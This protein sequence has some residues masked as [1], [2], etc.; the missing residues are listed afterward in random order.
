MGTIEDL[1]YYFPRYHH[2]YSDIVSINELDYE[3]IKT[4]KVTLG[5]VQNVRLKNKRVKNMQKVKAF[6]DDGEIDVVW[7]NQPFI[8]DILKEGDEVYFAA[9]LNEKSHKPQITNPEYE[10]AKESEST[11]V[12]RITPIYPLTEG[13]KQKW[14]RTKIKWLIDKLEFVTDLDDKLNTSIREKYNLEDLRYSITNIHFPDSK[15]TLFKAR[16]R[17][18][19][20]EMLAI[21]LKLEKLRKE[22]LKSKAPIIHIDEKNSIS[23]KFIETLPFKLTNDQTQ[24]IEIIKDDIQKGIPMKRLLHGD[25]GSGKTL[26]AIAASLEVVNSGLDAVIMAP[27]TV[28]AKQLHTNFSEFLEPFNLKIDLY[29]SST[30]NST[31]KASKGRG[32]NLKLLEKTPKTDPTKG[33][34]IIGTHSLLFLNEEFFSNMGILVIDEQHRF[35]VGQRNKISEEINKET[36]EEKPHYLMMTATPIPRTM[37]MTFFGDM[38]LTLISEKPKDRKPLKTFLVP[39]RKRKDGYKWIEDQIKVDNNQVFW[40]CPLID[41]S[42]KLQTKSVKQTYSELT[43]VYPDLKIELLHGQLKEEEKNKLLNDFKDK[44]FDILVSTSVIEVGIDIPNANYIVIEGAERFGL[45]QLH[46][47]RGR[48]GRGDKQAY[49][50]LFH[51]DG[52]TSNNESVERLKYF[53][54]ENDGLKIAEYDLERRGPGEVYGTKQSGIPNLRLAKLTDVELIKQ[55]REAAKILLSNN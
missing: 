7:F 55:T 4:I 6:D 16:N 2:D 41:E 51:S 12:G 40:I 43:Q 8:P 5:K 50:F 31:N 45:A 21:Q 17:L 29:T 9:K 25:V 3:T 24:S 15:D 44:K 11:H 33:D 42:E 34:V 10:V 23:K 19:F 30:K 52:S 54:S 1:L 32:D 13:I 35:G 28:L 22:H 47:L 37:A 14:L 49:C 48:V 36:K 38:D 39:E 46:Q 18:A 53:S 20:E 27:T 26:V